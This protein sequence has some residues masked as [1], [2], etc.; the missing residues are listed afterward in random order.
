MPGLWP[1][2]PAGRS[3]DRQVDAEQFRA[4][5]GGWGSVRYLAEAARAARNLAHPARYCER[6]H[7]D[8]GHR[9]EAADGAKAGA[10]PVGGGA[11]VG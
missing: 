9:K 3:E 8:G 5:L 6:P 4:P 2:S 7:P 10:G 11:V 1:A